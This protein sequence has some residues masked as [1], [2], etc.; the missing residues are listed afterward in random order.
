VSTIPKYEP[1]RARKSKKQQPQPDSAPNPANVVVTG[2]LSDS[3]TTYRSLQ[4]SIN[5]V[6]GM[7][8]IEG[9]LDNLVGVVARLTH[10]DH[11]V[12][13]TVCQNQYGQPVRLALAESDGSDMTDRFVTALERIADSVA[14]L[15]GLTRPRL[16]SWHEQD[17]YEPRFKDIAVD[18]GAPGPKQ[19]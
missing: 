8:G 11:S 13:V 9:S 10:D 15:A 1:A 6:A 14:K 7:D 5:H 19:S 2:P 17:E 16:E 3:G 18:G 4:H 12:G